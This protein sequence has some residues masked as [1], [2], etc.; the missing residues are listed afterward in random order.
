MDQLSKI[1]CEPA[2]SS[3]L[4][5]AR[6]NRVEMTEHM[7]SSLKINDFRR[8]LFEQA[9]LFTKNRLGEDIGNLAV[10]EEN[11]L[12]I[13]AGHQPVN[14]HAGVA[15]KNAYLAEIVRSGDALGINI[16]IDTDSGIAA[17][18]TYP[19]KS[20]TD[21]YSIGERQLSEG[22]SVYLSQRI[23]DTDT[24]STL[25][26]QIN[27]TT[28]PDIAPALKRVEDQYRLSAADSVVT[29]LTR[30]RR[31]FESNPCYLEL[32]LTELISLAEASEFLASVI[33]KGEFF[34]QHFNK[35]L[36]AFR[37]QRKIKNHANPFPNLGQRQD[38]LELPFW[39][40]DRRAGSRT[41]LYLRTEVGTLVSEDGM[42]LGSKSEAKDLFNW[43]NNEQY[44]LAP[45]ALL[46]TAMLRVLCSDYFIHGLGGARYDAFLDRLF[47]SYWHVKAPKFA[48]VSETR[49]LYPELVNQL[50]Q[51]EHLLASAREIQFHLDKYIDNGTFP[52]DLAGSL[53]TL[54]NERNTLK[55]QLI[56]IKRS[57]AA[58]ADTTQ[59]MK[60]VDAEIKSALTSFFMTR[61]LPSPLA[62]EALRW[63]EFPF[64][65][66]SGA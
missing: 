34:H 49:Y 19:Q 6:Q 4:E 22:G 65:Y 41:A 16:I 52:E 20:T 11:K 36:D 23:L 56:E 46:I 2:M 3:W 37:D 8:K 18:L 32:P 26:E 47:E 38:L 45:R 27:T 13:A 1:V 31:Y 39:V 61:S 63:R 5:Q 66:F 51:T 44:R 58:A 9:A 43:S 24:L 30:I 48:V 25:F 14:Y 54:W 50:E 33:N 60:R 21:V 53:R 29:G 17:K 35:E 12:I 57:G 62:I 7:F 40:I 64:M 10:F 42:T 28:L 15:R 55:E 59:A